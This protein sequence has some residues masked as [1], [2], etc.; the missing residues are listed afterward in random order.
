MKR[1]SRRSNEIGRRIQAE[2]LDP[3]RTQEQLL[4]DAFR[5]ACI[6]IRDIERKLERARRLVNR[7][8]GL[9]GEVSD[10]R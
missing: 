7:E 8:L 6:E 1:A 2:V 3:S 9:A 4:E 10:D 5:M